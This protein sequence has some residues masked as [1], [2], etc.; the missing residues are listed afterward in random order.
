MI[1][2]ATVCHV[3]PFWASD[4][5]ASEVGG[6]EEFDFGNDDG[7]VACCGGIGRGILELIRSH[8][9]G[10]SWGVK[11][12]SFVKVWCS[13][14]FNK[15]LEGRIGTENRQEGVMVYE[16]RFRLRSSR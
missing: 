9:K 16:K 12:A 1:I 13:I 6:R 5:V 11:D 7:F 4:F 2:R 8:K 15:A 10:I 14:I 3:I